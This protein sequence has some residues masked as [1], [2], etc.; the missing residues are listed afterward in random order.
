MPNPP[1]SRSSKPSPSGNRIRMPCASDDVPQGTVEQMEPWES[2]IFAGTTRD[3]SIYV[4]AQYKA[5]QPAALMVFQ[6]GEGMA[7]VKGRWRVPVVFDNLI[8]RGDMP[9][10]IAVFI[11]P[12]HDK[13]KPRQ[14]GKHSNRSSGIRQS[15]RSL[16]P[17][18]AGRN[19]SGSAK[20]YTIS[21]D[22]EMHAIGG[23]SSGAI[24]AF[25]A[26]WERTDFFRKVYSQRRQLHESA[27]RQCLSV[28]GSQD[29]TEA[30]SR[31]HGRHQRRCRQRL[32]KLVVGQSA[33]GVGS[34]VHGL[35]HALRSGP[36]AT[37][38][39]PTSAV[40]SFPTR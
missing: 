24:C 23:S 3:W 11:N 4:P 37:L 38:T 19:H 9:P 8:A 2:K 13:S 7:N 29:R 6:D 33:D 18:S 32:R 39:T 5:D 31:L 26:A 14:N 21:D 40:R 30:D 25:T 20:Q 35:R 10:T 27:R 15:R 28:A 36:K 16:R 17:L 1:T 12:G 22:P 34:E